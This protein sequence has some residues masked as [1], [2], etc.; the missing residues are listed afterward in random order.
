VLNEAEP[1]E[2]EALIAEKLLL[3]FN[4]KV[5]APSEAP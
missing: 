5:A 3:E 4:V 1:P 2:V